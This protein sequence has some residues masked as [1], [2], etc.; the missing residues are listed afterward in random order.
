MRCL[1]LTCGLLVAAAFGGG[2]A[3]AA[4][5]CRA[6]PLTCATTMPLGGY[7]ECTSHGNVEGGTV[8]PRA[9]RHRRVNSTA[10]GCG[11]HPHAPGC[12]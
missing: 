2:S 3:L 4:N 10:G 5:I 9:E 11:T 6:G 1:Y 12:R 8:A 7:C